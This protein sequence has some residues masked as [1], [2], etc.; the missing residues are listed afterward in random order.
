MVS[1]NMVLN[2]FTVKQFY[3]IFDRKP[4]MNILIEKNST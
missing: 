2:K 4:R 1:M 3:F